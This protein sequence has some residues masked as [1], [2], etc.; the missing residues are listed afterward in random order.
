V[1]KYLQNRKV[2]ATFGTLV[3]TQLQTGRA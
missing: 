1:A 3:K 2:A